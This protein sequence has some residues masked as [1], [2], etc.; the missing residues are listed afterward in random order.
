MAKGGYGETTGPEWSFTTFTRDGDVD[1]DGLTN[2][3]EISLGTNPLNR[4]SDGD[5][6]SDGEEVSAG[7]NPSEISSYPMAI[8]IQLEK[9]F[10]LVAIPADVTSQPD[11]KDWLPT[12]G[13][14]TEI[15][16]VMALDTQTGTYVTFIPDDPANPSF[17]LSGG[18]GLIVYA[19]EEKQIAFDNVLCASHLFVAGTNL[20]GFAC[21]ANGYTAY[22]LLDDYQ[23]QNVTS[24][25]RYSTEEGVFETAGFDADGNTVGV[26]FEIV[27]GEGYLI[28]KE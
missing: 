10:N 20:V 15:E 28:T 4:D 11:L 8:T 17:M 7:S 22:Q 25:Q 24:I 3:H 26:D 5:G 18:E 27:L 21:P 1:G 13:D 9:G 6:H 14:S 2:D 16:M 23:S 12:F 19:I